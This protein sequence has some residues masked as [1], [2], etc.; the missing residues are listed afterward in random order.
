MNDVLRGG[1]DLLEVHRYDARREGGR[2][3]QRHLDAAIAARVFKARNF[4]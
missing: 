2:R 3:D 4:T 1:D